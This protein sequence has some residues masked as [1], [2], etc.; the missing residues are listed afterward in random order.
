MNG[1]NSHLSG[2]KQR[3]GRKLLQAFK[4]YTGKPSSIIIEIMAYY[5]RFSTIFPLISQSMVT[6]PLLERLIV[7]QQFNC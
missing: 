3:H 7:G 5:S 1:R 2:S 6:M 4:N